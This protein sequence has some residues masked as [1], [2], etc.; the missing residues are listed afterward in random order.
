VTGESD[1]GKVEVQAG[2]G[3]DVLII[4]ALKQELDA[5]LTVEAGLIE[6]WTRVAGEHPTHR[7]IFEGRGGPIEIVAARTARMGGVET[8]TLAS[9]LFPV[10]KPRSLAMC[11]VC[12]GRPGDTELGDVIIADRV[13]QYDEG[14]RRHDGWAG[15]LTTY[16]MPD[17]WLHAAQELYG[18]AQ[19][20]AGYGVPDVD[21]AC[22]WLLEQLHEGHDPLASTGL[23]RYFP[24]ARWPDAFARLRDVLGHVK[25]TRGRLEL[26]EVGEAALAEHRMV[27]GR[28][29]F[30][31]LPYWIHV[32]PMGSGN[33]VVKDA[34][35]W[36][37]I[38]GQ[39]NRKILGLEMEAATV[40]R[41]AHA[42]GLPFIVA[43]GVMDHADRRKDDRAK[44]FAARA[45]AEVLCKML[46]QVVGTRADAG[47]HASSQDKSAGLDDEL[48][49]FE[50]ELIAAGESPDVIREHLLCFRRQFR[51]GPKLTEGYVLSDRY[52]LLSY[53]GEGGFATVWK[54]IDRPRNEIVAVKVLHGQWSEGERR[55]R[56]ESG[57]RRMLTL[58][59][60]AIVELCAPPRRDGAYVYFVMHWYPGLDLRRALAES[61]IDSRAALLAIARALD[62]LAYAHAQGVVHR[63]VKPDNILIDGE[64]RGYIGDF[65]LARAKH[66][67]Q[68]TRTGAMGTFAY[69]APEQM[70]DA[71]AVGIEADAYG[72]GMCALFVLA[73]RDP[74]PLVE[75]LDPG[76]IR[77]LPCSARLRRV[78]ERAV[79]Y[80]P[81]ERI[82]RVE[83]IAAALR[84]EL[85]L[86][87]GQDDATSEAWPA[88]R[89]RDLKGFVLLALSADP[90][91]WERAIAVEGDLAG[92]CLDGV[93]FERLLVAIKGQPKRITSAWTETF[94]PYLSGEQLQMV[95]RVSGLGQRCVNARGGELAWA[96]S[97]VC[98]KINP[99]E[100]V[101]VV[102]VELDNLVA[103]PVDS[104]VGRSLAGAY[105]RGLSLRGCD[106]AGVDLSRAV[107]DG[108]QLVGVQM[109]GARL[110]ASSLKGTLICRG[111]DGLPVD[112]GGVDAH[113]C[114]LR[115][116]VMRGVDLRRSSWTDCDW[117]GAS[118]AEVEIGPTCVDAV[119]LG[120]STHGPL[121]WLGEPRLATGHSGEITALSWSPDGRVLASSSRD[122]TIRLWARKQVKIPLATIVGHTGSVLSVAWSPDGRYIASGSCDASVRVWSVASGLQLACFNG[123]TNTVTSVAWSPDGGRLVSGGD[124]NIVRVWSVNDACILVALEG[125]SD[126]V[127]SVAWSPDGRRVVSGSGDHTIR[128]W[129]VEQRRLV[130]T[131]KERGA[132]NSV[133][134]SPSGDEIASGTANG[135]M[136]M[137]NAE[138]G[139]VLDQYHDDKRVVSLAW[140]SD[141]SQVAWCDAVDWVSQWSR[142]SKS[143]TR[144][145]GRPTALAWLPD[146]ELLSIGEA[147]GDVAFW[148]PGGLGRRLESAFRGVT[149]TSTVITWS[150]DGE[151]LICGDN[152]GAHV[153][154]VN[155]ARLQ[156]T[157]TV[158]PN[159]CVAWA[160]DGHHVALGGHRKVS[161]WTVDGARETREF[162]GQKALVTSVAWSP[163]GEFLASGSDGGGL[164]VWHVESGD[165]F[166][167]VATETRSVAWSP[168]G[169]YLAWGSRGGVAG[170]LSVEDRK[171][172]HHLPPLG[173]DVNS[174]AW[175]PD[176]TRLAF[177]QSSGEVQVWTSD[178]EQCVAALE[179]H[180]GSVNAVVWSPGG[181]LLA[182]SSADDCVR[183]WDVESG[184]VRASFEEPTHESASVAWS[185]D[186]R[187]LASGSFDGRVAVLRLAERDNGLSLVNAL[188]LWN[189]AGSTLAVASNGHFR[190]VSEDGPPAV[191]GVRSP[192]GSTIFNL[193]LAGLRE[194]QVDEGLS[195]PLASAEFPN[196]QTHVGWPD[197]R[198]WD[199]VVTSMAI[200]VPDDSDQL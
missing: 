67:T 16:Q 131:W 151:R 132:V 119:S 183:V 172:V 182:S 113:A 152:T 138:S 142:G 112:L 36:A 21:E 30:S 153:W 75:R 111:Q 170:V 84:E 167:A 38:S 139:D 148:D 103:K 92:G 61:V 28:R 186:G 104:L 96:L 25:V 109:R 48:G 26:T 79:A 105:L 137:R 169:R 177:A 123:H 78:L 70:R 47:A 41:V 173:A 14:K 94:E 93:S 108:A 2:A 199:G 19:T 10:L 149:R 5:L 60:E 50:A 125:H 69:A 180:A 157:L 43:K 176:G 57:G 37:L 51:N 155:G 136:Q 141:S 17:Q 99:P 42:H 32:G 187:Y 160:P 9:R 85:A 3:V 146:D 18:P 59:H 185:P 156:E 74:P 162:K 68:G 120:A 196:L 87:G 135:S 154:L 56:F 83:E 150:P 192:D 158:G 117:A 58:K 116:T 107:L 82:S 159:E 145:D 134:W 62:G 91:Y 102:T 98:R 179:G 13:L 143:K 66:S 54:A 24:D 163:S 95:L 110:H 77:G 124:D 144:Y 193:P 106:L 175:S 27:H 89:P 1:I 88:V 11:G 115:T 126:W 97:V 81:T 23:D 195:A 31:C 72:A 140:S 190:L 114:S 171:S 200:D 178:G 189:V 71:K 130:A 90:A 35:V 198:P 165:I 45:S 34:D 100:Q 55:A 15:D 6:P 184:R 129:N 194:H 166:F 46:R 44:G 49:A 12:A 33:Y 39:G 122:R 73:G 118:L 133:A 4:T 8:A 7:A 53:V 164:V 52:R 161:V 22:W 181:D 168:D 147:D 64:G 29:P 20:F 76:F 80:E 174:V 121:T 65:D 101:E 40:G 127:S 191:L 86:S 63:D 188:T 197:V 128:V